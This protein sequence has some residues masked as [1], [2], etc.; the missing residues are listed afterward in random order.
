MRKKQ[1]GPRPWINEDGTKK[2]EGEISRLGK[3]WDRETWNRFLNEDVGLPHGYPSCISVPHIWKSRAANTDK[4]LWNR[5]GG[6]YTN[7]FQGVDLKEMFEVAF[8]ELA[9]REE[10][11]IR[12]IFWS[13]E[14]N[15]AKV[16][17]R[18]GMWPPSLRR[19]KK[20]IL[21]KLRSIL[22]SEDFKEKLLFYRQSKA[23]DRA[24]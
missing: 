5:E 15:L 13:E 6:E 19:A 2:T 8:M 10:E 20:K 4:G 3:G 14:M 21:E 11:I 9:P 7:K 18:F 23:L 1:R 22:I 17:R 12:A 16:A 24:G